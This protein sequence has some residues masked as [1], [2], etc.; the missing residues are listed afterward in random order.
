MIEV[1]TV[2]PVAQSYLASLWDNETFHKKRENN[3]ET[4][5]NRYSRWFTRL[6]VSIAI[7]AAV[8][9]IFR[10]A[11]KSLT[12]FTSMLIVACPCALAH[13]T[14][15]RLLARRNIYL[16]NAQVL[17]AMARVD[18]MVLDKTG[19][20]TIPDAHAVEFLSVETPTEE[21]KAMIGSLAGHSL[22]PHAAR[23]AAWLNAEKLPVR[24]FIESPGCGIRGDVAGHTVLLGSAIWLEQ[25]DCFS[26]M[27]G[28]FDAGP[29]ESVVHAAIDGNYCVAFTLKNSLRPEVEALIS[30]A[31]GEVQI[32]LLSGDNDRERARFAALFGANAVLRF[33]Q[34]PADKLEYIREL[35]ETGHTVMMVGD[36]LNDAGALKQADVGVAVVERIGAFSPAS[37]VILDA[38]EIPG[39]MRIL[40]Y[41]RSTARVIRAGFGISAVYN[42]GGVSIAAVGLLAP[43]VCAILMPLSTATVVLFSCAGATWAA[44]R[45]GLLAERRQ[46]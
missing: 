5:T 20:L 11:A 32:A 18:T 45:N 16:K 44:R 27:T 38:A 29:A 40:E 7:A 42:V 2:K 37:D 23:I 46:S 31:R 34:S 3:L 4:V 6:V 9:W 41:S 8:F 28:R 43:I 25:N 24:E 19:T 33:N 13:G 35:Q 12:A 14:A 30:Q 22:H 15:Q 26:G 17:E 10:D 36:G 1:E 21:E 39:L